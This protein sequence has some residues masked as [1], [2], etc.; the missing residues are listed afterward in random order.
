M[1]K[2]TGICKR[3][4]IL[5]AIK[6]VR[7]KFILQLGLIRDLYYRKIFLDILQFKIIQNKTLIPQMLWSVNNY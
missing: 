7:I 1:D 6:D 3:W 4:L 5:K 2:T